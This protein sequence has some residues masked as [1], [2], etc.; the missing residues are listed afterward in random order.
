LNGEI[1]TAFPKLTEI[2]R[3]T[4]KAP[5]LEGTPQASVIKDGE[6]VP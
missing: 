1:V 6:I 4:L 3:A 2:Q 5:P